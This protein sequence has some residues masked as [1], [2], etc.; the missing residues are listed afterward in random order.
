MEVGIRTVIIAILTISWL[1]LFAQ[2][3]VDPGNTYH[4]LL[5]IVPIV[6]SGTFE[7]PRRPKYAPI[8]RHMDPTSRTGIIAYAHQESDDG[9]FAIVEF[10]A[11]DRAAFK[12]ILEDLDP[13]VKTFAKGQAN[14]ADIE[15]EFKK[16]KKNFTLDSLRVVVL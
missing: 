5:C 16:L 4:R 8:P 2:H 12:E 7:D 9:K 11:A 10:V 14:R 3:K 1:P 6:G 13:N 15:A